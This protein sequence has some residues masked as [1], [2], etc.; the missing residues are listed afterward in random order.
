MSWRVGEIKAALANAEAEAKA[1][2]SAMLSKD[3]TASA[4]HT[5]RLNGYKHMM[6]QYKKLIQEIENGTA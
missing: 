3:W 6:S 2:M 1:E 5:V 4:I